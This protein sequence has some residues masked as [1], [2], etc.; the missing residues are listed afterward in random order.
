MLQGR[1]QLSR[2]GESGLLE[3]LADAAVEAFDHAVCLG[4]LGRGE[5]VFDAEGRAQ[6][7]KFVPAGGAAFVQTE[8]PAGELFPVVRKY[9]ADADRTDPFQI[10]QEAACVGR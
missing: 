10:A 8:Q 7:I 4:V 2:I 5:A 6:K 3:Q 1:R 9:G